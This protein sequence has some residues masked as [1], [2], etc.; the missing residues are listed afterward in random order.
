MGATFA[1]CILN[2]NALETR[3][4]LC[5][6]ETLW[7]VLESSTLDS[8][9]SE[10]DIQWWAPQIVS[11]IHWCHSVLESG[12]KAHILMFIGRRSQSASLKELR[13]HHQGDP[14]KI[15]VNVSDSEEETDMDM[16]APLSPSPS[17]RPG[18]VMSKWSTTPN[19]MVTLTQRS[20][21]FSQR[22]GTNLFVKVME[23]P[24]QGGEDS[25]TPRLRVE[26]SLSYE[27]MT[28]DGLENKHNLIMGDI[29]SIEG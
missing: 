13:F 6:G 14:R 21:N 17:P 27:N 10:H 20:S 24:Q 28:S 4:G 9:I 7:D 25:S 29:H 22:T 12:Q 1:V 19:A 3:H 5:E 16:E 11:T 15:P 2:P 26:L 23:T 8:R 18:S